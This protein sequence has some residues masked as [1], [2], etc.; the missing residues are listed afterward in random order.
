MIF[1]VGSLCDS[2]PHIWLYSLKYILCRNLKFIYLFIYFN[3]YRPLY[4]FT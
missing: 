4:W 3:W 1:F 2:K